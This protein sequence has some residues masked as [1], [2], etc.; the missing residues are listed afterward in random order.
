MEQTDLTAAREQLTGTNQKTGIWQAVRRFAIEHLSWLM[1]L[2]LLMVVAI[3]LWMSDGFR[4]TANEAWTV[5][6]SG[7]QARI[8]EYLSGYG[9]WGPVASVTL[10]MLQSI[11]APIPASVV[12]LANGVV[13]GIF[14]GAVL[15]L[16]G[17]MAGA[18]A[19]FY[20]ARTLGRN[21]AERFA[22]RVDEHGVIE[23][24]LDRWGS[25]ALFLI[26]A[27]PGMPSDFASYLLGLSSMPARRYFTVS[28]L[29]YIPQS[30]AYSWLGDAAT[31]WFW[32][33]VLAGFGVSL[34][35]GLVV[36]VVR[37]F[38]SPLPQQALAPE[39]GSD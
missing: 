35:I 15:N 17:Q 34:V 6:S 2:C 5:L 7:D 4:A 18:T 3:A 32:W 12:Q 13:F 37:R 29:G 33:I 25:K 19:A 22:G 30:F 31:D 23:I 39:P 38:I 1:L 36:W 9:A 8:R 10:M 20:I 21:T 28:L 11:I 26:R 16:I 27:V 14:G 24:W